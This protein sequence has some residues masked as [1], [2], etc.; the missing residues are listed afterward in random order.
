MESMPY[1]KESIRYIILMLSLIAII[2]F[3]D[4]VKRS[5]DGIK[6]LTDGR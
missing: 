1:D 5:F 3:P 4:A 6:R 2:R